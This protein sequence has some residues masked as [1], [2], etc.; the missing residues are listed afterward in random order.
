MKTLTSPK[1]KTFND[2]G[3]EKVAGNTFNYT[4]KS[5]DSGHFGTPVNVYYTYPT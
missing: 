3:S 5:A 2:D 4:V 1:F